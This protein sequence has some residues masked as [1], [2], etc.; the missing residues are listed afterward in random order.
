VAFEY[1]NTEKNRGIKSLEADRLRAEGE[2]LV[3]LID[4]QKLEIDAVEE[5]IQTAKKNDIS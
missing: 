5:E 2:D 4:S 1:H 3:K